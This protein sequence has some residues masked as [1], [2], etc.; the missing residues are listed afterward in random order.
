MKAY[1]NCLD[2]MQCIRP[3]SLMTILACPMG[4]LLGLSSAHLWEQQLS[5]FSASYSG[6]ADG[7]EQTLREAM[8]HTWAAPNLEV[9][10]SSASRPR[11][12]DLSPDL[13]KYT[14][15]EETVYA[16]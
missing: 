3:S 6:L 2:D 1:L 9:G 5:L 13:L 12:V 10:S 11:T 7:G 16:W 15:W 4:L 14:A 8:N